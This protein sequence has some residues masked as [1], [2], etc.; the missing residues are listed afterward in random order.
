MPDPAATSS[1]TWPVPSF[2]FQVN[3]GG[4]LKIAFQ[5]V[6][7]LD[8]ETPAIKFRRG[9]AH[10]A[11]PIKLPG[12]AQTGR[13]TM[14]RGLC[15]NDQAFRNWITQ[16]GAKLATRTNVVVQLLDQNGRPTTTWTLANA[17]PTNLSAPTLKSEGNEVA[18][19]SLDV[20]Y[21]TLTVETP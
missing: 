1:S 4:R 8:P 10:S 20:A 3:W 17:W 19:E 14:K 21:E 5:Q 18:I 13:V 15:L 6:S 16:I 2:S 9:D 12:L 7:G 11:S